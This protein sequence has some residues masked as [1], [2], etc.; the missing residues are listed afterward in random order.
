VNS[1]SVDKRLTFGLHWVHENVV[2][3]DPQAEFEPKAFRE[4]VPKKLAGWQIETSA[5]GSLNE[6][7]AIPDVTLVQLGVDTILPKST[8][9]FH[10][11]P[12][13]RRKLPTGPTCSSR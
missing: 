2:A 6:T 11:S 1:E 10:A 12:I 3:H 13:F 8:Q 5:S 4:L 7:H 9:S